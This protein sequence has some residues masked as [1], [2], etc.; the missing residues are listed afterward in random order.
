MHL[1]KITL[2]DEEKEDLFTLWWESYGKQAW[3]EF[4]A[5]NDIVVV[6]HPCETEA[7]DQLQQMAHDKFFEGV[8]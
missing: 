7:Q 8:E 6:E 1:P 5:S 3:I 2:N 4:A